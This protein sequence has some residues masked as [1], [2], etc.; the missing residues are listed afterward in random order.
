MSLRVTEVF[1]YE[2]GGYKLVH[3]HADLPKEPA[4]K[5]R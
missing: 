1:R 3:R 4:K 2:H 5:P